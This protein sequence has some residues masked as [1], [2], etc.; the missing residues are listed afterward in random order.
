M[1]HQSEEE[2]IKRFFAIMALI[3]KGLW[4]SLSHQCIGV[5][6]AS[7]ET[8]SNAVKELPYIIASIVMD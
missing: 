2:Y 4:Y 5:N 1:D 8:I 6:T 7:Q 3:D